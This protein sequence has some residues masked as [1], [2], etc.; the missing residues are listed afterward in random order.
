MRA[1]RSDLLRAMLP[2]FS[3][4]LRRN[5]TRAAEIAGKVYANGQ[6]TNAKTSGDLCGT[7]RSLRVR[8][9]VGLQSSQTLPISLPSR[10]PPQLNRCSAAGILDG[11]DATDR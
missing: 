5:L 4:A 7:Q 3:A 10:R 2:L 8:Q 9:S 11:D 1:Q 6:H